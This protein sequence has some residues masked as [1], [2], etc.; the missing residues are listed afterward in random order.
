VHNGFKVGPNYGRPPAP[1]AADWID[2]SDKRKES[3]DLSKW[4]T[5]FDDPALNSLICLAYR[6]NLTL[7]EAAFRATAFRDTETAFRAVFFF[8][9]GLRA[10]ARRVALRAVFF[11]AAAF[12]AFFFALAA[13]RLAIAV[14]LSVVW[15]TLTVSG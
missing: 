12:V 5:V 14:V 6:Q 7:R 10:A 15:L 1:L 9:A 8:A 4:W 13:F 11:G 2:T 3:E